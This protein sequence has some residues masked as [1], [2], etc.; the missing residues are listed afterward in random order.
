LFHLLKRPLSLIADTN[1]LRLDAVREQR[2]PIGEPNRRVALASV[3]QI[4]P[5]PLLSRFLYR[6]TSTKHRAQHRDCYH[7]NRAHSLAAWFI[8]SPAPC[9]RARSP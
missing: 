5:L 3:L 7:P 1:Q 2:C 6:G 8:L 9:A 4:A